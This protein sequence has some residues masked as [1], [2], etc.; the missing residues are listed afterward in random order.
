MIETLV[1][2]F[3]LSKF[4]CLSKWKDFVK[5]GQMKAS[6]FIRSKNRLRLR[7]GVGV[8]ENLSTPAP[9]P[10]PGKNTNSSRLRSTPQPCL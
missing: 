9:T 2:A 8:G 1:H 6:F 3:C 5:K 7:A 10:T 4:N